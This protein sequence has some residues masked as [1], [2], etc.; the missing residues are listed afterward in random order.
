MS[1]LQEVLNR[2]KLNYTT[3]DAKGPAR[4]T[5][6]HFTR[7]GIYDPAGIQYLVYGVGANSFQVAKNPRENMSNLRGAIS[8][9]AGANS[10]QIA[11][12]PRENCCGSNE[13]MVGGLRGAIS[14]Q[15]GANSF[16]IAKDPRENCCGNREGMAAG[17]LRGALNR[18]EPFT[19]SGI[20]NTRGV[21]YLLKVSPKAC[22]EGYQ[23][24]PNAE[25]FTLVD[26]KPYTGREYNYEPIGGYFERVPSS[27]NRKDHFSS[28]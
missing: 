11:K 3:A 8:R 9:Q 7:S 26:N 20:Y 12:N 1:D 25:I 10:F 22:A 16:Q 21:D 28:S 23:L 2:N 6:E 14:R 18:A 4:P 27:V 24:K 17:G 13:G 19:H 5:S 15:A